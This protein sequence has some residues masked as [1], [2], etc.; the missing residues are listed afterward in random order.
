MHPELIHQMVLERT[1]RFQRD[2]DRYRRAR[3]AHMPPP[4]PVRTVIKRR[5]SAC[6]QELERLAHRRGATGRLS[7]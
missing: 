2:A 6:R 4:Q 5:L 7:E 1:A 3:E